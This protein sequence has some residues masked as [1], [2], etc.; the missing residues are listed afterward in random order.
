MSTTRVEAASEPS[1]PVVQ[2]PVK[3]KWVGYIWDTFDKTP[4]E[5]RLLFKLDSAILT[6]ASLGKL[7]HFD[8]S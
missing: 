8:R 1:D 3:R 6:F 2:K 4:E 5:R 7:S